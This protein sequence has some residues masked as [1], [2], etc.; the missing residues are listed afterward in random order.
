MDADV[1]REWRNPRFRRWFA[2]H[3]F[4]QALRLPPWQ[5]GEAYQV[6]RA[7]C[8]TMKRSN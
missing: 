1:V 2:W 7:Y 6:Y 5:W 4:L 3:C 8:Q